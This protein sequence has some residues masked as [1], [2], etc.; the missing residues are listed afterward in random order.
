MS[1]AAPL[2]KPTWFAIQLGISDLSARR[3]SLCSEQELVGGER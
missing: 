3:A 1:K 2:A